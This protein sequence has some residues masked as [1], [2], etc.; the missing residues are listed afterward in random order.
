MATLYRKKP[1]GP[2]YIQ[3]KHPKTPS[4]SFE[5]VGMFTNGKLH[6]GPFLC[7]TAK[8]GKEGDGKRILFSHMIDGRPAD[9]CYAT[10]FFERKAPYRKVDSFKDYRDVSGH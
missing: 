4:K 9:K 7:R 2:A 6:M 1:I 8:E 3:Y 5:G 10:K